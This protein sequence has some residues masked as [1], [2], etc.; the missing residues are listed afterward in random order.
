MAFY[1]S[2]AG[3]GGILPPEYTGL[4]TDPVTKLSLAFDPDVATVVTTGAHDFHVPIIRDDAGAAWVAEGAEI[5]PDDPTLSELVVTPSKVAGLTI[6]S[7]ELAN[8]SSPEAMQI[9]GE[10]LARSIVSQVDKA[11]L[12]NLASPAPKGLAS[13]TGITIVDTG[14]TL[15]SLDLFLEAIASAEGENANISAWI[16]TPD[17]ALAIAQLKEATGSNKG[18]LDDPRILFGRPVKIS[19][20]TPQGVIWGVDKTKII[21]VLREDTEVAVSG[22]SHF[23]SDR[24]AI[25]AT[26]RVG[27]GFP[28][29]ATIVKMHDAV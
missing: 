5:T 28:T 15:T 12:G 4:I 25:R 8:D 3:N 27:F 6:V 22:D 9:V 14:G 20:D 13:L 29:P 26:M 10:G 7:R 23:T 17:M 11:F 21:T 19:N 1:T 16:T 24:V 2:T 18:L